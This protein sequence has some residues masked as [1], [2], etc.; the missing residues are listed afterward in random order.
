MD[1]ALK[2][3]YESKYVRTGDS[4]IVPKEQNPPPQM[5]HDSMRLRSTPDFGGL[6]TAVD[7]QYIS[8]PATIRPITESGSERYITFLGGD[9]TNQLELH[10]T[11]EFTIGADEGDLHVFPFNRVVTAHIEKG[12]LFGVRVTAVDD[13]CPPVLY[14]EFDFGSI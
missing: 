4:I 5:K 10:A 12:M 6:G 1:N 14:N 9:P 3:E 11:V 13:G 7:W 8:A 2:K